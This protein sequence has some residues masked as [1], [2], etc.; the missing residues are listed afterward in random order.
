MSI[1]YTLIEGKDLEGNPRTF[2]KVAG[3]PYLLDRDP[4]ESPLAKMAQRGL[5]AAPMTVDLG[6]RGVGKSWEVYY[7]NLE[8]YETQK[9]VVRGTLD[10]TWYHVY[11]TAGRAIVWL[12]EALDVRGFA[13][14]KGTSYEVDAKGIP[15]G[16]PEVPL[17]VEHYQDV[18]DFLNRSRPG[19]CNVWH[20]DYAT[21]RWGWL[22][23]VRAIR[24]RA[25]TSAGVLLDDEV[26]EI[27][28]NPLYN[29]DRAISKLRDEFLELIADL[30]KADKTLEVASQFGHKMHPGMQAS[31]DYHI[32]LA[33]SKV[34]DWVTLNFKDMITRLVR[35]QGVCYGLTETSGQKFEGFTV[36][37]P[38]PRRFRLFLVMS[39]R[40]LQYRG[41]SE[42][43]ATAATLGPKA[44]AEQGAL[45]ECRRCQARFRSRAMVPRCRCGGR[46]PTLLEAVP[47]AKVAEGA[48]A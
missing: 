29:S 20:G 11:G 43:A 41:P 14:E 23:L 27:A 9:T 24:N 16:A 33:G 46:R 21:V 26:H 12:P 22:D 40:E 6:S 5:G 4:D 35:G 30:R 47:T 25:D 36:P 17:N 28:P 3:C 1:P 48:S 32:F 15:I 19:W 31:A 42:A 13:L 44:A 2:Y 34:P 18:R 8:E 7:R 37:P 39:R 10:D 38:P 45:Y